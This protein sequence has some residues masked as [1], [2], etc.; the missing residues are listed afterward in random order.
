MFHSKRATFVDSVVVD[1]IMLKAGDEV[2]FICTLTV[3]KELHARRVVR[4]KEAPA[5]SKE[6][7]MRSP[8]LPT[9]RMAKG[10]DGSKGFAMGRG[11]T[12]PRPQES[13]Q[14]QNEPVDTIKTGINSP[15]TES[16]ENTQMNSEQYA[17]AVEKE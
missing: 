16:N 12:I 15:A 4:T 3:K 7:P 2:E 6:A 10:P 8:A 9:F 14:S 5:V 1:R 17:D 11:K 13:P